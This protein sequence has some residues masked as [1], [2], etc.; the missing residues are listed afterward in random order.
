[1]NY[2]Y[3]RKDVLLRQLDGS[4]KRKSIR[5]KTDKELNA[6]IKKKEDKAERAYQLHRCPLFSTI[7]DDWNEKHESEIAYNTWSGYQAPLKDLKAEFDGLR[8]TEITPLMLQSLLN[9]FPF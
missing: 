2:T 9:Q 1:M 5:A 3:K 4:Y 7:A 8:I 6:K